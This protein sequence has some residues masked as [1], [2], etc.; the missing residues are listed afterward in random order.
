[1]QI[2]N[3]RFLSSPAARAAINLL[4][5][6]P[7]LYV[8]AHV[9][10]DGDTVGSALGLYWALTQIG[11]PARIA[12]ADPMPDTFRFLPG[13]EL[14]KAQKPSADELIVILDSSDPQRLGSLYD[15]T[16]YQHRPL[17]N[18]DHHVTNVRFGTVNWI[19]PTAAS[20]AEIIVELAQALGARLD[21]TMATCLLTGM[22]TDT[23]VFRTSNTTPELMETAARLMRA[24]APLTPIIEQTFNTRELS[25]LKLQGKILANLCVE[26]GLIW[27]D[28]TLQM[29]RESGA[30]ESSG[31]GTGTTLLSVKGAKVSVI[32]IEKEKNKI[33]VS[34]RARP[35]TNIANVALGLGGGGHPQ[36][37][38][39]TLHGSLAEAHERVLPAVRALL[40]ER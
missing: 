24:G 4:Q 34:F 5:S 8:T 2:P 7:R 17:V 30:S 22:A 35:G 28:N 3:T 16:L 23:L 11:K 38:G 9:T 26:D 15:E 29:R 37:A 14:F 13:W 36:A 12:C 10:P 18:I 20:T 40:G 19:E 25:D 39:C 27:S 32:F 21:P 31:S 33:E 6:A 1:M